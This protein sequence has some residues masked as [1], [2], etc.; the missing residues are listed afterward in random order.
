MSAHTPTP[1]EMVELVRKMVAGRDGVV[2]ADLF[3]DDGVLEYPFFLPGFP[4]VYKG[5]REIREWVGRMSEM[6]DRFDVHEVT[7]VA[8]E[9]TDPE[10]VIAEISHKGFSHAINRPYEVTALGIIRVR[11]GKIVHYRDYM[12]PLATAEFLG[13]LPDVVAAL[14]GSEPAAM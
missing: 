6:R 14:S 1:R 11:A 9:T 3:A 5:Q 13:R 4:N 7:A 8:H 10:L 2:F 12:N